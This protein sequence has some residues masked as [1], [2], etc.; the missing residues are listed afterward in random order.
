MLSVF[1]FVLLALGCFWLELP[2]SYRDR[3]GTLLTG[4]KRQMSGRCQAGSIIG[5]AE[6]WV[7]AEEFGRSLCENVL[8]CAD[9]AAPAFGIRDNADDR[10][11]LSVRCIRA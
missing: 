9:N 3:T 5:A 6:W 1:T 7:G 4:R 11:G 10:G 8:P 2:G